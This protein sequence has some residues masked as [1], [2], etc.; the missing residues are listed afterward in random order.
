MNNQLERILNG[1]IITTMAECRKVA[2]DTSQI[3]PHAKAQILSLIDQ[4][5]IRELESLPCTGIIGNNG[6]RQDWTP[7][8]LIQDHIFKLKATQD[9]G[10]E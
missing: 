9:G 3:I 2:V 5:K 6:T 1:V 8:S 4:E 7:Y 10:S